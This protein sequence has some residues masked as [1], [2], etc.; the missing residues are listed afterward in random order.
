MLTIVALSTFLLCC[1]ASGYRRVTA[2]VDER[3]IIARK[4]WQRCGFVFEATLRKH[5]VVRRRNCNTALYTMLNTD[6]VDLEG[7][8]RQLCGWPK[9]AKSKEDEGSSPVVKSDSQQSNQSKTNQGLKKK[10]DKKKSGKGGK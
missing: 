6:W 10:K 5:R 7:R 3:H 2:E 4:F 9:A 8:L 1:V